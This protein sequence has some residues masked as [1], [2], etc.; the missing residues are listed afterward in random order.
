MMNMSEFLKRQEMILLDGAMGTQLDKR[1]LMSR[2]RNNLDAP[3]AVLEIHRE[4]ADC[5]CHALTT[6][7]LTMNRIYI[8]TH[9]VGVDVREVNRAGAELARQAASSNQYVL[10]DISS[11]GQMLEPYGNYKESEF[12]DAFKEQAQTL[13]EANVDGFIIET[14]FDLRE[15]LCALRAC[16]DNFQLPV[17][18]SIAFA[19]E[20]KGGRTMMG[21][22]AEDC[23][24]E[25]TGA[26]ADVV[27]ANC[28]SLDPTQTAA[29]VSV[30][31]S[32]TKL[33]I[34]A[35]PNAGKPKLV[36]DKTV[37]EMT[38]TAF[39]AGIAECL[40]AGARIVGGCCGTTPE[41]I[42]T[43]AGALNKK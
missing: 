4:Y 28:G 43:V 16:K 3:E 1:G 15:A 11:T 5:G 34:L 6:N 31:K 22:S 18:A 21:N 9:N 23:A 38:P 12:Y 36:D 24:R 30:L 40:R 39:A 8:E 41:H 35:Q 7:T 19:T 29:I 26:G 2:G 32:A 17:I 37:F 10:G 20:E 25:L 27:G 42:R 33:P 13:S 14:M